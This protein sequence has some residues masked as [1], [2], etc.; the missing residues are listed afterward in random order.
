MHTGLSDIA[1]RASIESESDALSTVPAETPTS[2]PSTGSPEIELVAVDDDISEYGE[3]EPQV[4]I[5]NDDVSFLDPHA[6]FPTFPYY[7]DGELLTAPV[8]RLS[9]YLQY[10]QCPLWDAASGTQLNSADSVDNDE[11]FVKLR[12]WIETF[13]QLNRRMENFSDTVYRNRDFFTALP[14]IFWALNYRRYGEFTILEF[15]C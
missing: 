14:E 5:I 7:V 2:S 1:A 12:D 4:A 6:N 13:L 15:F 3:R 11:V 8:H 10:G 9:R